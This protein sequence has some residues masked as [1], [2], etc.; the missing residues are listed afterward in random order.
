M[1]DKDSDETHQSVFP[2]KRHSKI[3]VVRGKVATAR[4]KLKQLRF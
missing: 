2:I 3:F 1:I 4:V